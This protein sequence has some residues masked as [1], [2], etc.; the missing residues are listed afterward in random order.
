[1]AGIRV[2]IVGGADQEN[3]TAVTVGPRR[4]GQNGSAYG[5][6]QQVP[7]GFQPLTV[8]KTTQP[9]SISITLEVRPDYPGDH[10]LNV[11]VNLDTI[12]VAE[13]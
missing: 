11:T 12:S 5:T 13:V 8:F 1:M 7:A 10:T 4:W 3:A 9:P 6:V 2:Y